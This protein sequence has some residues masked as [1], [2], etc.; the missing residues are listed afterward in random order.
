MK[1][2]LTYHVSL[3]FILVFFSCQKF[4]WHNPFDPECPKDIFTPE[5]FSAQLDSKAIRLS[6][7]QSNTQ[8]SGFEILRSVDGGN[9]TQLVSLGKEATSYLDTDVQADKQYKYFIVAKAGDNKSN[10]LSTVI[11]FKVQ[12][13]VV[14]ENLNATVVST[15]KVQLQWVDR[16]T[17]ETGFKVERKTVGSNY[18]LIATLNANTTAY[19]DSTVVEGQTYFYRVYTF[20][21][22]GNSATYSNEVEVTILLLPQVTTAGITNIT[23]NAAVS[24]GTNLIQNGS[25]ITAKGIVWSTVQQPTI[26]LSTKT[27]NGSGSANYSGQMTGL[28]PGTTY[29]V[30]AYV[31]NQVGTS[32]G[33]EISFSTTQA[34]L[35]T[36]ST[37]A[38]SNITLTTAQTGGN[39]TNDGG[40][41]VLA[42]GVVWSLM[43]QPTIA[44]ST[45]TNDGNGS[46]VFTSNLTGLANGTVYFARAY[47][48]T[49]LGTAYGA[50]VS[51]TTEQVT[52]SPDVVTI[53]TQVWQSKNLD[54][55]T[56][57]NGDIIPQVTDRSAWGQ[58]TTGAWCWY[59][60]NSANGTTYGRLYNWYAVNDPR[61]LAPAGYH[62]P[63][64][65]E[66][67][68]LTNFLGGASVAGG[69]MKSTTNWQNPNIGATNSS[70]FMGLPGG[71]RATPNEDFNQLGVVGKFWSSTGFDPSI[72]SSLNLGNN[73]GE[74]YWILDS[75]GLG[76]SVRCIKD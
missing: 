58:L 65:A 35:P 10:E 22:G 67:T 38:V 7:Q 61:G 41:P 40:F 50:D 34:T 18:G 64:E 39:I 24:G 37:T 75:K 52:T 74:I 15:S 42:R 49:Q 26:A 55:V 62:I 13:P 12:P 53:G 69:K 19:T 25:S 44:L 63:T 56:Y 54:V 66:W 43:P 6:W 20:N 1:L 5:N 33:N 60:N 17:E 8:I 4:S 76:A 14:P 30:R 27:N 45:K 32:Y 71:Y 28:T 51:F 73:S 3:L 2:K 31:T 36:L 48:T 23:I 68:T 72:A 16:S 57:R 29:Y 46:G 11:V 9:N 47:A 59:A 70:G 21:Q